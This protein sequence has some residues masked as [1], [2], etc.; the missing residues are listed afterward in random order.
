MMTKNQ[1]SRK[2]ASK[3]EKQKVEFVRDVTKEDKDSLSELMNQAQAAYNSYIQ[4][5]RK[6]AA[7]YQECQCHGEKAYEEIEEQ[8]ANICTETIEKAA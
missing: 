2:V 4:A 3:E 7:A 5:Q 1:Q 8:A 6:V